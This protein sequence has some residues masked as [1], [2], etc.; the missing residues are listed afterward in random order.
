MW[1]HLPLVF[2]VG[3]EAFSVATLSFIG[4]APPPGE[5]QLWTNHTPDLLHNKLDIG[6]LLVGYAPSILVGYGY[7]PSA[8]PRGNC[9]SGGYIGEYST[10]RPQIS[11]T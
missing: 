10:L 4:T 8:V 7:I 11:Y 5:V 9:N 2:W 6:G 3:H 1:Q